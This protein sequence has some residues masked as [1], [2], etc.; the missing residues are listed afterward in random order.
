M[1]T[2]DHGAVEATARSGPTANRKVA[3]HDAAIVLHS[4][5]TG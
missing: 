3:R 5:L 1:E 2:L 4:K